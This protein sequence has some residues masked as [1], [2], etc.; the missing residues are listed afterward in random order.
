MITTPSTSQLTFEQFLTQLPD[1]EGYYELVNGKL[2]RKL[3]TRRHEDLADLILRI[4]DK[5]VERLQLNY[6][7]SGRIV[8]RTETEQGQEQ[9]RHPDITV[10]NKTL[11]EAQPTAYSALLEPPQLVVEVVSTN[12][13]DDYVDKLQEYQR[14]GVP[15]YWIVDYLAVASRSYLGNP[16]LAT[17]F[18]CVLN[19]NNTYNMNRYQGSEPIISPTFPE[20]S[21]TVEQLLLNEA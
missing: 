9:G 8:I 11:W 20:L 5:E 10:V 18:V 15:E 4:F 6:R 14:L 21:F 17:V 2:M 16:K 12:W 13:E 19:D 1:R 7:V 3:P